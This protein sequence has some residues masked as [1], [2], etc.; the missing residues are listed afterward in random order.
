MTSQPPLPSTGAVGSRS[1]LVTGAASGIGF[2]SSAAFV[3]RGYRVAML[4]RDADRLATVAR[5][6]PAGSVRPI[7]CDITDDAAT[8]AAVAE[9]VDAFGPL[10]VVHANAGISWPD[11]PVT[12]TSVE[13]TRGT[14]EVN[15]GGIVTT[16]RN[17]VPALRDGGAV[18]ITSSIAGIKARPMGGIYAASKFGLIG[19]GRALT[20]EVAPRRIRVNMVCPGAVRTELFTRVFGDQADAV[21]AEIAAQTPLGRIAE[22]EDVAAA[23]V[24]LAESAHVNGTTLVIDGGESLIGHAV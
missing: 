3:Q 1:A 24:F 14:L 10:D 21:I 13:A 17:A 6:L 2:A 4:D 23:V 11:A 9:C 15:V 5:S 19:L 16:L 12:E 20:L 7:G 8:A 22:P 18:V